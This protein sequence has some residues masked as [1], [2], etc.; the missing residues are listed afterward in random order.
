[1]KHWLIHSAV[2]LA[3]QIGFAVLG[4]SWP[5][6]VL[7]GRLPVSTIFS[8]LD[9]QLWTANTSRIWSIVWLADTGISL[10]GLRKPKNSLK[11][12]AERE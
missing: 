2:F 8:S 11:K 7:S 5:W 3:A 10:L 4:F 6:E 9:G 1:M 12:A